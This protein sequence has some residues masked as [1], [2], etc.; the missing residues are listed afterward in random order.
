MVIKKVLV[1][2]KGFFDFKTLFGDIE[3]Y[4][5]VSA[6]FVISLL[7]FFA[8]LFIEKEVMKFAAIGIIVMGGLS[9]KLTWAQP[10]FISKKSALFNVSVATSHSFLFL[11][12]L[13]G[14]L[15]VVDSFLFQ[16]ENMTF[17]IFGSVLLSIIVTSLYLAYT[18][19]EYM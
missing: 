8:G 3:R 14:V 15:F 9:V 2:K 4:K 12:F 18:L 13:L 7:F 11:G 10:H 1:V 5:V 6:F 16:I 19:R 17:A